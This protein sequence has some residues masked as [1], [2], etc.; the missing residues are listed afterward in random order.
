MITTIQQLVKKVT[1]WGENTKERILSQIQNEEKEV[2]LLNLYSKAKE[3]LLNSLDIGSFIDVYIQTVICCLTIIKIAYKGLYSIDELLTLFP[4]LHSFLILLLQD[5]RTIKDAEIIPLMKLFEE[6]DINAIHESFNKLKPEMDFIT[7]FYEQLLKKYNPIEKTK[8]GIF[9]TATPIV[10]FIIRSAEYLIRTEFNSLNQKVELLDP[11][12]G[13]GAFLECVIKQ[14]KSCFDIQN[15]NLRRNGL[16]LN[17]NN[18]INNYPIDDLYGFE[19]SISSF[20]IAQL[21]LNL[22]LEETGYNF[23]SNRR[24]HL[25]LANILTS[26]PILQFQKGFNWSSQESDLE[27]QGLESNLIPVIVGNPPYSRSSKNVGAYINNLMGSYKQA[28]KHERNIQA[29]SDDYIKFIRLAQDLIEKSGQG[30]IGM[31]TNHTYLSGIIYSGMR[32]ELMKSFDRIYILDLH[33]SKIIYEKTPGNI[34][35]E[36]LFP[37]KQGICIA[38]FL[39]N[40]RV[41][42][43]KIFHFDLFGS[44]TDKINWLNTNDIST[45]S[46]TNLSN[47][48]P[49]TPFINSSQISN[50]AE[51]YTF[52]SL[53]ELFEFYNVGGKPGDDDLLVSFEPQDSS[54]KLQNFIAEHIKTRDMVVKKPTSNWIN[55]DENTEAK[56]KFL[57]VLTEFSLDPS[58]LIKYN[59]RPFDIRWVYYDPNI[60]TRPV[61]KLKAQCQENLLLLCSRIV[62]DDRFSHIFISNLFTDVIFLSNTSSVNCYVFPLKKYDAEGKISWNLS[63]LYRE[64]LEGMGLDLRNMN[65]IAPIAYIYA[66]LFSNRFRTRYAEI[67]KR[68]F[69]RI[70]FID[71]SKIF[72]ELV[73]IGV[74]LI[75]YHL[76]EI[77]FNSITGLKS[78]IVAN[79]RIMKGF[80]KYKDNYIFIAPE[81]WFYGISKE[82]WDFRI[83]KY[84]ICYKWIKDRENRAIS[85]EEIVQYQK[86]ICVLDKTIN[87]MKQIDQILEY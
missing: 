77:D 85:K 59:Y 68:D 8:R 13:T 1:L 29:L 66:I 20:I 65:S 26:E 40:P 86:I 56:Q 14:I 52:H 27:N 17:W 45:V 51:Y 23:S 30:L 31:I 11:A 74:E 54:S 6:C 34:K 41:T 83:G 33:G 16:G 58:K 72:T 53:I 82:T 37:I 81:K 25:F 63:H 61:K 42:Q 79:D 18:I 76:L 36:N 38:F 5:I 50:D 46:W 75:K 64:Y 21:K 47:I 19:L 24:L 60:W 15:K 48:T 78:N 43:K 28:V 70:P 7:Y 84:Q 9:H 32:K 2:Y 3:I 49:G 55:N 10:S 57:K 71:D 39:K 62:K 80:P 22:L 44:K 4:N 35:D 69:P 73:Q 12:M 67:L 87:L